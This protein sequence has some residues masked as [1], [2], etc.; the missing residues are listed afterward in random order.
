VSSLA[1]ACRIRWLQ[2]DER[3]VNQAW[4]GKLKSRD[5]GLELRPGLPVF[6]YVMENNNH[7]KKKAN[8]L[9][10]TLNP[11]GIRKMDNPIG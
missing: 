10:L 9:A 5:C 7:V 1:G 11:L 8:N 6:N 2:L 4:K 3:I